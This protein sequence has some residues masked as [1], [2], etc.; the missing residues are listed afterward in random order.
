VAR[1]VLF[2][3][4]LPEHPPTNE[5][6]WRSEA[7]LLVREGLAGVAVRLYRDYSLNL[8]A[9]VLE[10]LEHAQFNDMAAT[11]AMVSRSQGGI[12]ALRKAGIPF[13]ITKG[14]GIAMLAPSISDR[15]F[16]DLDLVVEPS[17][18]ADAMG[19]LT[20][21]GYREDRL[22]VQPWE[23]FN[24]FCREAVNLRTLEGGSIDLHHRI[25]PWYWSSGLTFDL[26]EDAASPIDVF[27]IP[28][29]LISP[30][31]N[32]L[33]SALHIVSDK[34]RPGQST[35]VWRDFLLLARNCNLDLALEIASGA[36]LCGWLSWIL[37]CLPLEFRPE[38][39]S[40][41]LLKYNQTIKGRLRLKLLLPPRLGSEHTVGQ[42]YRLPVP[43]AALFAAGMTIPSPT[44]L[45]LRYPDSPHPYLTWW[46]QS[47]KHFNTPRGQ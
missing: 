13:V 26:L 10:I 1:F 39:L 47:L 43:N 14:P 40:S 38:E 30:E 4:F 15:P 22:S 21:S 18:F 37:K 16:T 23:S 2:S 9:D 32:L 20:A 27:G 5:H 3:D 24:R 36:G 41:K 6:A 44:F 34:G 33:V 42:M 35:R 7:D 46:D 17:R 28:L 31:Q 45:N 25:A 11:T 12:Q 19:T 29:P 8:P